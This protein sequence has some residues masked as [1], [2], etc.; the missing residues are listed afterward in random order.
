MKKIVC[1]CLSALCLIGCSSAPK[2]T[3]EPTTT[4][5]VFTS[6]STNNFYEASSWTGDQL[7]EAIK[8]RSGSWTIATVN[9]DNTPNLA[10]AV[11]G[12]LDDTTLVL[13]LAP[14]QTGEN[15]VRT[16]E[17]VAIIY[18]YTNNQEIE[19]TL[20]N[21]GAKLKLALVSE[22]EFKKYQDANPDT[23]TETSLVLKIVEVLPLG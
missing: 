8:N 21:Q 6:A 16:K 15:I 14:N 11:F 7:I 17:A 4:P 5:D 1:I 10:V 3:P 19:K 22:E 18:Q 23:V 13:N 12:M 9:P 2:A 20:R